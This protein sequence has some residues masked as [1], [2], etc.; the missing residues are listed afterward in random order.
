[1]STLMREGD[2]PKGG[3]PKGDKDKPTLVKR[4]V[5]EGRR[6]PRRRHSSVTSI[7]ST[8]SAL[9]D[10]ERRKKRLKLKLQS[11]K[12]DLSTKRANVEGR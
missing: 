3:K 6:P 4:G 8:S 11:Y 10:K 1:M 9:T 12:K 7:N 5:H 2:K